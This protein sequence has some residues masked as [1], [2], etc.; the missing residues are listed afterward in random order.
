[1]RRKVFER[2][3]AEALAIADEVV[4]TSIFKPEA[5][6]EHERL[7]VNAVVSQVQSIGRAA[8][9]YKDADAIVEGISPYVKSGDVIAILSN[10][11]FGNIYQK[12]PK[13]LESLAEVSARS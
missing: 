8:H 13:K 6:A 12:L 5:I 10:G 3:L 7:S 2:E 1:L 9:E 11:G 4:V